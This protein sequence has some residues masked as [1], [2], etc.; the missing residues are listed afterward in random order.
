MTVRIA[1]ATDIHWFATPGLRH[2]ASLKRV[3]GTANL[4]L[5]GR[6]HRFVATVQDALVAHLVELRP[7]LV[8]LTGD[9]T[10]Q[11]LP[12]EFELARKALEPVLA[13]L[14]TLVLPGNHDVYTSESVRARRM[15]HWFGPWMGLDGPLPLARRDLGNVTILGL[16]P[17]RPTWVTA[18]GR[19]PEV[20]IQA[21]EKVL[22]EPDLA[23]RILVLA[24]YY[25]P[26]DREGRLYDRSAHGLVNVRDLVNVLE[27]APVRPVLIACGHVHH[28]FRADL[29]LRD[30]TRIPV[31]DCGSS[32]HVW[33]PDRGRG[34]AMAVYE[35]DERGG[36][37]IERYLH[38]GHR[39]VSEVGGAFASGR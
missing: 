10:S 28:G 15:A 18:S 14:P 9:L 25:P 22:R 36:L 4:Y 2:H 19:I 20:Q 8:L 11:A 13:T 39:F 34:A 26:L 23:S 17:N 38:D 29:V 1:H 16:D 35:L 5:T 37:T 31:V 33:Q 24:I 21:L 30:G 12:D 27:R 6:R 3:L 32:G 7:D